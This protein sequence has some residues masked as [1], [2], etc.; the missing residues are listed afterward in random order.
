MKEWY[1]VLKGKRTG[2]VSDDEIQEF[3]DDGTI[4]PDTKI[5]KEGMSDWTEASKR[6]AIIEEDKKVEEEE[7]AKKVE[8]YPNTEV[9]IFQKISLFS[10]LACILNPF[11]GAA[12]LFSLQAKTADL[13]RRVEDAERKLDLCK[14]ML[15][16]AFGI[17]VMIYLWFVSLSA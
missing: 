16:F 4:T 5:W 11:A 1:Y 17:S 7:E 9:E 12:L 14:K 6:N 10:C 13:D 2:P 8:F 15:M 3:L